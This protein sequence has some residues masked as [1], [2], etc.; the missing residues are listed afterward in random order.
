MAFD[1]LLLTGVRVLMVFG[2]N[3]APRGV[4]IAD[5]RA[6]FKVFGLCCIPLKQHLVRVLKVFDDYVM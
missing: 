3:L 1:I 2:L 5:R 4:D 6:G